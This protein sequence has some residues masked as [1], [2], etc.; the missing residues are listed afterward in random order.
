MNKETAKSYLK[1]SIISFLFVGI[2]L[3]MILSVL[4]ETNLNLFI[5]AG[6]IV[7]LFSA[8][9]FCFLLDKFDKSGY[10]MGVIK[11]EEGDVDEK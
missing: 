10:K 11:K 1:G 6:L 2:G 7:L 4:S 9:M 8:I 5:L 3:G